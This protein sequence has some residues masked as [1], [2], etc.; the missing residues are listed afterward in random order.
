MAKKYTLPR[1]TNLASQGL[2]ITA[3]IVDFAIAFA[4][5]LV[6]YFAGFNLILK[7]TTQGLSDQLNNYQLESHLKIKNE[8]GTIGIIPNK[9]PADFEKAA[10]C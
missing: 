8:D 6:F 9:D 4:L 1:H 3:A 10:P 7:N 5:A 2:R